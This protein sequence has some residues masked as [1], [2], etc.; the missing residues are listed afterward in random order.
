[1]TWQ[2]KQLEAEKLEVEANLDILDL[3]I[4]AV[5]RQLVSHNTRPAT[6]EMACQTDPMPIEAPTAAYVIT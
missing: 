1:M 5:E 4:A 3:E 2:I 6:C